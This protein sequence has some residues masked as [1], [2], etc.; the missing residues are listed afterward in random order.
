MDKEMALHIL[1]AMTDDEFDSFF[2]KLPPRTQ[3][4]LKGGLADWREVLPEW[5]I[6]L[7]RRQKGND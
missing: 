4:I 1:A 2:Q 6:E 3:L 5:Y 7:A